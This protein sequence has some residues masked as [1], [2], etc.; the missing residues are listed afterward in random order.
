MKAF[1]ANP[2]LNL[3]SI[4]PSRNGLKEHIKR[5]C[6]QSS[7]L[8]KEGEKNIGAQNVLDWGWRMDRDRLVPKWQ[9]NENNFDAEMIMKTCS[10]STVW[11]NCTCSMNNVKCLIY[12]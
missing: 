3:R 8:W 11:E 9:P 2:N 10:C 6:L 1:Q 7:W 5:S 4:S 12:C